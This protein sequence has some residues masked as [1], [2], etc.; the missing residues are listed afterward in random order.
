[1]SVCTLSLRKGKSGAWASSVLAGWPGLCC[2]LEH[3]V[4]AHLDVRS[5]GGPWRMGWDL[6]RA[7]GGGQLA[8]LFWYPVLA[9]PPSLKNLSTATSPQHLAE[10]TSGRSCPSNTGMPSNKSKARVTCPEWTNPRARPEAGQTG[11]K[12]SSLPSPALARG[13]ELITVIAVGELRGRGGWAG[14][15]LLRWVDRE[16]EPSCPS[17]SL[18]SLTSVKELI[19]HL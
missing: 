1:M 4:N 19:K 16:A 12:S 9:L 8:S 11:P 14:P 5:T 17:G 15:E 18:A 6:G 2:D 13:S 3:A 7:G 10:R